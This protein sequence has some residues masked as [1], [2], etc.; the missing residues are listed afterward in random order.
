MTQTPHYAGLVPGSV[1]SVT[2]LAPL[3]NPSFLG[4]ALEEENRGQMS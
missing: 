4:L 2:W 3:Q 1:I